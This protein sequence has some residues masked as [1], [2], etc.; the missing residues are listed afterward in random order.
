MDLVTNGHF[1]VYRSFTV[2][3]LCRV[4]GFMTKLESDIWMS[5][6]SNEFNTFWVPCTWFINLLREAKMDCR[7][8]DG[9]G[10]KLIM[11]VC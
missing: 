10:V 11:E 2:A 6:P 1:D 3:V 9:Y 8:T 5:I 7:V 4:P